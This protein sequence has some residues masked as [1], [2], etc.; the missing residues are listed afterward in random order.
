MEGDTVEDGREK[1]SQG[2]VRLL[3]RNVLCDKGH[4]EEILSVDGGIGE[5]EIP[6]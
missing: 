6:S 2:E 1:K 4:D 5:T 3:N